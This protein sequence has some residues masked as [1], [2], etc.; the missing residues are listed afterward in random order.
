MVSMVLN[1]IIAFASPLAWLQIL[2]GH[3]SDANL[4]ARGVGSLKYYTVLSNLFSA[5]V[6]AT[7]LIAFLLPGTTPSTPMLAFKLAAAAVVMVTFLV[8]ALL[9]VPRHG[10]SLYRGGNFWL[11]LVLPL[12]ALLDVV[13]YA[14]V[15]TLPL[16]AT[17]GS[18]AFTALYGVGYLKPIL[19][20]G[21]RKDGKVYDFYGFLRWGD[22]KL[23]LVAVSLILA[24]WS[25]ALAIWLAS[26][27]V[28]AVQ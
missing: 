14:P 17:W 28:M 20:H 24:S 4:A 12:C 21:A 22:D 5:A 7:Y 2:R 19:Q 15:G 27:L 8:T 3:G 1:G 6:S 9:L 16:G 10:R 13:A 18:A 26:R 25:I 11:H 23:P